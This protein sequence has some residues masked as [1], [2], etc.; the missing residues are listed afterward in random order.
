MNT[1][2][3]NALVQWLLSHAY[4]QGGTV[5]VPTTSGP[6]PVPLGGF[7]PGIDDVLNRV[8]ARHTAWT[9]SEEQVD[10][11]FLVGGPG[12]GKSEALRSLASRLNVTLP[13]RT[14]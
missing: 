10:W 3:I 9:V 11:C 5:A 12:N 4:G 8:S 14:P 2:V 6:S 13:P 1:Y 7:P